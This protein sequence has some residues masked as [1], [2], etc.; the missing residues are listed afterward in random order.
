M[1]SLWFDIVVTN[2]MIEPPKKS[3][4]CCN[5]RDAHAKPLLEFIP[6]SIQKVCIRIFLNKT[7]LFQDKIWRFREDPSYRCAN[8]E[9]TLAVYQSRELR[10]YF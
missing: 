6:K 7:I 1:N 9:F 2:A 4:V 3:T 5:E 10:D 8:I